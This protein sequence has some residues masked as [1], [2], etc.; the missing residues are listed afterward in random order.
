M[1]RRQADLSGIR[2]LGEAYDRLARD[3]ALPGHFGRNL[4][5]LW[6]ALSTDVAGP[7]L[8]VWRRG[9][10]SRTAMGGDYD[11]LADL[12]RQLEARRADVTLE[13]D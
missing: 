2:S 5:A 4:D 3:L 1:S 10:A 12:L 11:R 7:L 8:I 6:D 13:I 9:A